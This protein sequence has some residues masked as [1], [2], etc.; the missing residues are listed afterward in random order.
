[1]WLIELLYWTFITAE[2]H[3]NTAE[4]DHYEEEMESEPTALEHTGGW[5][6]VKS[7]GDRP[8]SPGVG[9]KIQ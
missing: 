7:E 9:N 1:M 8:Q 4:E 3:K 6:E 2:F 5:M